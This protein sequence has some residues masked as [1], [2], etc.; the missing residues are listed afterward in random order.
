MNRSSLLLSALL[1]ISTGLFASEQAMVLA[2]PTGVIQ[3]TLTMPSG[4]SRV[5]VV[6]VIAGSGPTDRDGNTPMVPGK[7]DNLKMLAAAL[8]DNGVAA[9]RYDKRGIAASAQAGPAESDLRFDD[10]VQDAAAWVTKLSQDPRFSGVVVLGHSEGSLIGMLAAQRSPAVAFISLAGPAH[11]AS[12]VLR[13]QLQAQLPA[14][15]AA[16]N[17]EILAALE[18]GRPVGDVPAPLQ[19][20]Y[21]PTIRPYL[22]SWFQYVPTAELAKLQAPCLLVQGGTDIQVDVAD[23]QAL[24][25][26]NPRCAIKLIAGMNHVLKTVPLDQARQIASYGDPLLLLDAGLTQALTEFFSGEPLRAALAASR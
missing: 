6:L 3:G 15:L 21:R 10:F 26:A 11:R 12:S 23:A 20:L 14:D 13:R 9:V 5:P 22:M 1:S 19:G 18:T 4:G 25:A 2:T 8:R 16:R 7:N 17:D 24:H